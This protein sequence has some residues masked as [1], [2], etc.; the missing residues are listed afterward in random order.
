[1]KFPVS[2]K[3]VLA[4]VFFY[5]FVCMKADAQTKKVV[6]KDFTFFPFISQ[7]SADNPL[8]F[9]YTSKSPTIS[10]TIDAL[11]DYE[12]V[13]EF[14]DDYQSPVKRSVR[15]E[16][17]NGLSSGW[18]VEESGEDENFYV[19]TG[20]VRNKSTGLSLLVTMEYKKGSIPSQNNALAMFRSFRPNST[21][22]PP[23]IVNNPPLP[24]ITNPSNN[25]VNIQEIL[26]AHNGLRNE[27]GVGPLTWSNDLAKVAQNWA[28]DLARRNCSFEHSTSD[29]GENLASG[30]TSFTIPQLIQMWGDEKKDFDPVT[31]KCFPGRNCGHYTQ[32]VWR[33]TTKVGCGI[34]KCANGEII[35]VCNY[36]PA[37]NFN[38]EPAY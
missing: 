5:S 21:P 37:G 13:E 1:M 28:N 14:L 10:I 29:Y 38:D 7:K 27:R 6:M 33:K 31:R 12:S 18:V 20:M 25:S 2:K 22:K 15:P 26:A 19:L 30:G 36:D 4:F 23:V 24:P 11:E 9:P 32:V 3:V 8:E 16:N 34:A 17:I 35:L